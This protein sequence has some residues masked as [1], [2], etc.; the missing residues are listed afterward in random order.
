L[1]VEF[2]GCDSETLNNLE[3]LEQSFAEAALETGAT[4]VETTFR[5]FSP[6]GVSGVV[7]IEESHLTVHTWPEKGYAAV[8]IYT[9][10]DCDPRKAIPVLQKDFEAHRVETLILQRGLGIQ[11]WENEHS[12]SQTEHTINSFIER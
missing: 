7:I 5:L 12:I 6:Q 4:I 2:H 9:C 1:I 10:G 11:D 8:D 3:F